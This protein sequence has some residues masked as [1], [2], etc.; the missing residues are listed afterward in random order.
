LAC[1]LSRLEVDV[2]SVG[3]LQRRLRAGLRGLRLL[4]LELVGVGLDGEQRRASLHELPVLV[5]DRLQHALYPRDEI[6]GVDGRGIA[7]G[8][9]IAR[10]R[11]LHRNGNVDL[12]RRRRYKAVLFAAAQCRKCEYGKSYTGCGAP[13]R[14]AVHFAFIRLDAC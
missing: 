2:S 11:T 6:D 14:T 8:L 12:R 9:E 13:P 1:A 3:L 10:H 7:G 5:V 4:E